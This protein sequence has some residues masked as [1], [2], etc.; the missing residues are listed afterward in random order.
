MNFRNQIYWITFLF[1]VLVVAI[2]SRNAELF[3]LTEDSGIGAKVLIWFQSWIADDIGQISV[4]GF[5]LVS[6]YLFFRNFTFSKVFSKWKSR[7][8][9]IVLPFVIWNSLY[10]LLYCLF[11]AVPFLSKVSG[12]DGVF[13]SVSGLCDAIVNYTYNPVFWYL[14]QLILLVISAPFLYVLLYQAKIGIFALLAVWVAVACQVQIGLL[15]A[16]A[17]V[18]YMTAAYTAIHGK[19][20][21][22]SS[23]GIRGIFAGIFCIVV[24]ILPFHIDPFFLFPVPTVILRLGVPIGIWMIVKELPLPKASEWM[25]GTFFVYATHF[26]IVRTLNK[27][28]AIWFAGSVQGAFL[29]YIIDII[30]AFAVAW[31]C[32]QVLGRYLPIVWRA[33][34]GGR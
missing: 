19:K 18:Y 24:S 33:I 29:L 10:Y 15:N 5:F 28:G 34:S 11:S 1:S 12:I 23:W 22:E 32:R 20:W 25:K 9:S 3:A 26:L 31:L 30:S 2:H 7:M 6:G 8:L 27:I 14:F 17:L 16:D 21:V 13:W 4:P